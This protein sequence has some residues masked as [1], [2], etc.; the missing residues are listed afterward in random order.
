M[1]LP[2]IYE[3]RHGGTGTATQVACRNEGIFHVVGCSIERVSAMITEGR[4]LNESHQTFASMGL[5]YAAKL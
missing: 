5:V 4:L 2:S 1:P 3:S